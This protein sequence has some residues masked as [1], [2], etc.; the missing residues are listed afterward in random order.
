MN[1]N[2]SFNDILFLANS[3]VDLENNL[4]LKVSNVI[5]KYIQFLKNSIEKFEDDYLFIGKA[6]NDSSVVHVGTKIKESILFKSI[7]SDII[8]TIKS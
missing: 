6:K 8:D 5:N 1:N 7:L 3:M 2:N 4:K